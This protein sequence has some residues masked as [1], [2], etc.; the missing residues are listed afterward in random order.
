MK[1]LEEEQER[2][3]AIDVIKKLYKILKT[4]LKLCKQ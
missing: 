2:T 4:K 1:K 3:N